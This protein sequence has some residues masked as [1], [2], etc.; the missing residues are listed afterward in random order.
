[1]SQSAATAIIF[2]CDQAYYFLARGLVLSLADAGYPSADVGVV[3]IDIGCDADALAWMKERGVVIV[4]FDPSPLPA[5]VLS[6]ITPSQRA[7]AMR[8]WLPQLVPD[9]EHLIWLDCDLWLQNGEV[10]HHMLAGANAA[11]QSV[12]LAPGTS[13]Y[14]ARFYI[15]IGALIAMQRVWY[16]SC[17]AP[18]LARELSAIVHYSS[19][20]FGM[21]RASP[22]WGLWGEEVARVYPLIAARHPAVV[23]MAELIAMNIVLA[24]TQQFIRLD[25]LYNF[26]C[27]GAGVMRV[28]D[29]RVMTNMMM[30]LREV[31]VIHLANWSQLRERYIERQLLYRSGDYLTATERAWIMR[32]MAA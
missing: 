10:I 30:P 27:N 16:E 24:K 22:V 2:S 14:N 31:G 15:D 7:M 18:D 11:P 9:F 12:T 20:V 21:R 25:P 32:P 5:N 23:H 3:L 8:P 17:C 19:A 1:M 13:H 28:P 6:V 29:G 26:H 4:P